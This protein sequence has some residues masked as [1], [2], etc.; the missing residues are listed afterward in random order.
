M[1]YTELLPEFLA[2]GCRHENE[3]ASCRAIYRILLRFRGDG[4]WTGPGGIRQR[5]ELD[6]AGSL[7]IARGPTDAGRHLRGSRK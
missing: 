2:G 3:K 5:T 4:R 7:E 1:F 6:R